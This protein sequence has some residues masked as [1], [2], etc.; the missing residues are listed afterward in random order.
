MATTDI[1]ID[2]GTAN[3]VITIGKKG[4]VLSEP[5]AI[6]YHKRNKSIL[7]VGKRAYDMIGKTPEF[8][9]VIQPLAN[10]VI[11]DDQMTHYMIKEFILKV[12]GHHLVKPR[13]I[14]CVPS[15]ITDVEKR[16]VVEAAMSA[17]SRKAYLIDEPIAALIGAG[18]NIGKA[19]GNMIVDIGGGTTDV[20][21][22][23]M[24]GLVTSH[25]IKVAGNTLD[26]AI[27]RYMQTKYKLLI[28]ARTAERI[29]IELTN[30]YDPR[31][32]ITA[33][34]KGRNLV[35]GMPE[36]V[37]ISEVELFE[38]VEDEIAEILEAIKLV[39]EET[40]PELVG[41]IYENGV[42]LAGGGAMLSGLRKLIERT[43][44]VKC[45][46]AKDSLHCV[47][48][49][50]AIAFRKMNHLLDGFENVAVYQFQ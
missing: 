10:G 21:I 6:A 25:S 20:A 40:P 46:I 35:S 45:V 36:M 42:L 50:T 28:G 38:A 12:T 30:L 47:A 3:T 29:K 49:G 9:E 19:R 16:A 5:S 15:F 1:G 11:S 24:N 31:E 17:G 8:I 2:L 39:L 34:V 18:V 41:D 44:Q 23:S 26:Q 32:D 37:E 22:V 13:I 33:W 43:L 14:I 27:I 4:V 48:K 7:A